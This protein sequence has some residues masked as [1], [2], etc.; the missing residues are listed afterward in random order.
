MQN[1]FATVDALAAAVPSGCRLALPADYAGVAMALTAALLRRAPRELRLVCIP[2]AGLQADLLIGAGLVRSIETSAVSLGEAGGAPCFNRAVAS[3]EIELLDSTCPA[4]HAG[5]MA[6]QKGVP[7]A[8]LR[9]LIGSDVLLQ[10]GDW[11]VMQN[12]FSEAPDPIVALPA[13]H[14]DAAIFHA[15]MADR[16]GNVWIGRRRE[17]ASMA[18]ASRATY[19]TVERV[20]EGNLMDDER[21][22]AG[23]LP[24]LYVEAVALAPGGAW[25][26]GLWGEYPPDMVEMQRYARLARTVE[27][28][29]SYLLEGTFARLGESA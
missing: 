7:F 5:L 15:P 26:C 17:L 9:G 22:A 1:D 13:I 20:V 14:P 21:T 18:Y 10:R 28:F 27:G 3:G 16:E 2:T 19:V 23:V 25:P 6:A 12:P 24:A 8:T 29:R 4:V 11:R